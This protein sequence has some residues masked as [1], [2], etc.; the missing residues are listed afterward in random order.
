MWVILHSLPG[1]AYTKNYILKKN[2]FKMNR[3]RLEID[4]DSID[5]SIYK[6]ITVTINLIY[7]W[8]LVG[9]NFCLHQKYD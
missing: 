2:K 9:I 4:L 6:F 7:L 3:E 5:W 8:P 1:L